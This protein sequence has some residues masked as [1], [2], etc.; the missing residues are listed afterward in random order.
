MAPGRIDPPNLPATKLKIPTVDISAFL[1]DPDSQEAQCIVPIVR[2]AC[3]TTGF[4]QI[5]GHGVSTALQQAVFEGGKKFFALPFE[6]KKAL[7]SKTVRGHRGYD[8]LASQSYEPGILPDLKEGWYVGEDLPDDHPR[9]QAGRFFMG[10]NVWPDEAKVA[11]HDFREPCEEYHRAL[12]ALSIQILRLIARTLPYGSGIFDDFVSHHPIT[13]MRILHYPPARTGTDKPQYGASAHTDF[14]AI[15]LLLQDES[16]GLEV[17]DSRT[18]TWVAVPPN[19]NAYV[20]NIGDML[21]RWTR[22]E[23]VSSVHRVINQNPWDRYSIVF[24]FDGNPDTELRALD[25][26]EA[27]DS[28]PLTPEQHMLHRMTESYG[29]KINKPEVSA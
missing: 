4:F 23:Y 11:R 18:G 25:G 13:P 5:T 8:V 28:H 27:E 1:A 14:G 15:T 16:P 20:V 24:F 6:T 26:S 19:P 7:D 12:S 22:D 2:A 17:L 10:R 21:S 29:K 3:R 9:V